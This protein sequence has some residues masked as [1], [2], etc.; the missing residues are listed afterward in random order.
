MNDEMTSNRH[1]LR[2]NY[3]SIRYMNPVTKRESSARKQYQ[4]VDRT[5]VITRWFVFAMELIVV[6]VCGLIAFT[7]YRLVL[8]ICL[9][10]LT[11]LS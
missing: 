5:R 10:V 9:E 3:T 2:E 1:R 11:I 4:F 8:F 7:V 6:Y